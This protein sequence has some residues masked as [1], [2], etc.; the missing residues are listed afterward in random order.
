MRLAYIMLHD[1]NPKLHYYQTLQSLDS[2]H[3][4]PPS[5]GKLP[6]GPNVDV[7]P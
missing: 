1:M 2:M 6:T 4:L 5:L 3:S 7:A